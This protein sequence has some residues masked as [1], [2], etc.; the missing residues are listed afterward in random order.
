MEL[1]SMTK[2]RYSIDDDKIFDKYDNEHLTLVKV[3]NLLNRMVEDYKNIYLD[4]NE[5]RVENNQLKEANEK[6]RQEIMVANGFIVEKG[7]EKDFI[8]FIRGLNDDL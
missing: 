7:L 2:K 8:K 3:R 6:L 5:T 4:Y 1:N